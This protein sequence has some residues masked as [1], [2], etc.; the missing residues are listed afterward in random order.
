[1]PFS[2][3]EISRAYTH[4]YNLGTQEAHLKK[5][6]PPMVF[7][8]PD[9]QRAVVTG[10]KAGRKNKGFASLRKQQ[11]ALWYQ[12]NKARLNDAQRRRRRREISGQ[13]LAA[14]PQLAHRISTAA[15]EARPKTSATRRPAA[16]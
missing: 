16:A 12:Q 7:S 11:R 3:S 5:A 4:G 8:D 15:T 10:W 9:M 1:M 2:D 6:S 13:A 14:L